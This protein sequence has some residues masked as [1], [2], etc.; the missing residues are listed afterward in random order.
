MAA[1]L[2]DKII[3][4]I[5][6]R[7]GITD[8][9]LA[10][11]IFGQGA[12]QQRVNSEC[13]LLESRKKIVRRKRDD[14]LIGNFPIDDDVLVPLAVVAAPAI[15]P[16]LNLS[17]DRVKKF[18]EMWLVDRG[19]SVAIAW[20]RARG[21]DIDAISNGQRWLIEVKGEGSL[22]AMRVNYFLSMLGELLQ[23]MDDP[24]ARYSIAVPDLKQF[25]N[26]WSRLPILA[27]QRTTITALFVAGDGGVEEVA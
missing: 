12:P 25:R 21:V 7:P 4:E 8:R 16:P 18:L 20:E 11:T 27:K 10:E 19:W 23:R 24:V 26:L 5:A 15:K 3:R 6:A 13:R 2:L 22:Q 14:G 17:E 1:S 9:W